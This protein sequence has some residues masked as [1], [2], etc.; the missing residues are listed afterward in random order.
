MVIR[1]VRARSLVG[2]TTLKDSLRCAKQRGIICMTGIVGGYPHCGQPER[3]ANALEGGWS[4]HCAHRRTANRR[5]T[6]SNLLYIE[7]DPPCL[8]RRFCGSRDLRNGEQAGAR[9]APWGLE[10]QT[11]TVSTYRRYKTEGRK[12]YRTST[13]QS[14]YQSHR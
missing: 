9:V 12:P 3:E 1:P 5:L 2:T 8:K 11:S 13:L 7:A 10:P 14:L 4:V 6:Y